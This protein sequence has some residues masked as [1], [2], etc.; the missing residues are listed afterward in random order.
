MAKN[1][2][3]KV[4]TTTKRNKSDKREKYDYDAF[5]KDL[6]NRFLYPLLK[7]AQPELHDKADKRRKHRLLDKE[8]RDI[9]NTG[10][11]GVHTNPHFADLVLEIPLKNG[12]KT[13]ILLHVEAEQT[14]G[15]GNLAERMNHYRSLIYAH[16]R[17]EP[18]ALAIL[19]GSRRKKERFYS[20]SHFGTEIIYRYNNVVLAELDDGELRESDNP[21]D[22]VLY[23]AKCALKAKKELQRYKYLRTLTELLAER[24]WDR[25]EKYDLVLFIVR[26]INLKDETL[27]EQYWEYRQ[28]LDREGKLMYE[29]FLKQVEE[30]WLN[31][32]AWQKVLKKA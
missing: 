12:D 5:W 21:I 26:I 18:V 8:F 31:S 17:R 19:A 9:L 3:D 10:K 28:E 27:Q 22:V 4:K 32:A 2:A 24:G 29:P 25:N 14:Y 7:R 1:V 23:A 6:I 15:G 11:S 20:H 13:W 16:Y 30:K